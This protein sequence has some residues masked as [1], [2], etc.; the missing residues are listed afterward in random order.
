M[1]ILNDADAGVDEQTPSTKI[2][3]E[4]EVGIS[5]RQTRQS[6]I[7]RSLRRKMDV[8][9]RV[10]RPCMLANDFRFLRDVY[11]FLFLFKADGRIE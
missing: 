4:R 10:P 3:R 6:D 11:M 5:D 1:S 8:K 9:K 2:A 7:R